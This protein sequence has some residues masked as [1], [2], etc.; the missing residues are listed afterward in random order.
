MIYHK[1]IKL[2]GWQQASDTV[3]EYLKNNSDIL[4]TARFWNILTRKQHGPCYKA[5]D[6]VF[7]EQGFNLLRISFLIVNQ[8]EINIHQDIDFVPGYPARHARINIPV[9]NCEGSETRF[10]SSINWNPITKILPIGSRYTYHE[11]K[12]CKLESAVYN[13]RT[14]GIACKRITQCRYSRVIPT[15][16]INLCS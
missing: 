11:M 8:P 4:R 16:C 14:N 7:Q 1:R 13:I 15:Y 9:I 2:N 10:Y 3:Y 6:P 5:F 12:D